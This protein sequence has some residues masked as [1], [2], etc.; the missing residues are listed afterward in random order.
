M[1]CRP[2]ILSLLNCITEN[3]RGTE[4]RMLASS[5]VDEDEYGAL[6]KWYWQGDIEVLRK[7]RPNATWSTTNLTGTY[8]GSNPGLKGERPVTNHM[9]YS[10]ALK[11]KINLNSGKEY[12]WLCNRRD[13]VWGRVIQH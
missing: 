1:F 2:N 5:D 4:G 11:G 9:S 12:K 13:E 7:K 10:M 6:V 3:I 8:P